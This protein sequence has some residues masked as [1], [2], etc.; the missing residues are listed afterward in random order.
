MVHKTS[1]IVPVMG[2]MAGKTALLSA[3]GTQVM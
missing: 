2:E 3:E 1:C